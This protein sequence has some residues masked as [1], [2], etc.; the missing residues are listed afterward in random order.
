MFSRFTKVKPPERPVT[1]QS[2]RGWLIEAVAQ[3]LSI[4]P[5]TLDTDRSFEDYGLDSRAGLELSGQIERILERRLSPALLYQHP[6][7]DALVGFLAKDLPS[8]NAA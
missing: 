1:E 6:T 4:A 7:V 8:S 3:R 2:L 5:A